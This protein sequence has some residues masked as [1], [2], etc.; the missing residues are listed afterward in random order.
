MAYSNECKSRDHGRKRQLGNPTI[1]DRL[2]RQSIS[3]IL[4]PVYGR[5]FSDNSFGFRP[6]RS[7]HGALNRGQSFMSAGYK[8]GMGLDWEKFFDTVNHSKRIEILSC[9]IKNGRVILLIH[10]Y[11]QPGM[12]K[13]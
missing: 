12:M 1:V 9:K 7:T 3:Q 6:K 13:D 10:K 5:K 11:L 4:R 2:I 8:Y